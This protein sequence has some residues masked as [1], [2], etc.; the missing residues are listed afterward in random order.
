MLRPEH[1][2]AQV[3]VAKVSTVIDAG[4]LPGHRQFRQRESLFGSV[5][6]AG[7][8]ESEEL[9]GGRC[10]DLV[11]E[12]Q[13]GSKPH[14]VAEDMIMVVEDG[15][16][17][18]CDPKIGERDPVLIDLGQIG[19]HVVVVGAQIAGFVALTAVG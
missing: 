17:L 13:V 7:N 2:L 9:D 4:Q 12:G 15:D 19:Q 14:L 18:R 16:T 5:V 11:I 6:D 1:R 3:T 10:D 8:A